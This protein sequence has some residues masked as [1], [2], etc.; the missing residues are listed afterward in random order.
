M[1]GL[2]LL[3]SVVLAFL[4]VLRFYPSP[5]A[6]AEEGV[7]PPEAAALGTREATRDGMAAAAPGEGFLSRPEPAPVAPP[8][9]TGRSDA[10]QEGGASPAADAGAPAASTRPAWLQ[11]VEVAPPSAGWEE[12]VAEAIAHGDPAAVARVL[13][14]VQAADLDDDHRRWILAFAQAL[15]DDRSR[16]LTT[17]G[18]IAEGA[19][20]ES[21]ALLLRR[22]LGGRTEE[23]VEAALRPASAIE[24]AMRLRLRAREAAALLQEKRFA[25]AARAYTEVLVT[26]LEAPW[27]SD[28]AALAAWTAGLDAAQEGHRWNPRGD[29]PSVA[30]T[31]L[32][33]DHLTG[34]RKRYLADHPDR[35]MCTGLIERANA[36]RG[37][38]HAGDELR[39][40]IDPASVLVDLDARWVLYFLGDEVA[41][42]WPAGIGRAG[43]ETITGDF[44]VGPKE[45]RPVWWPAGEEPVPYGDPR[46]PLGSH[47]IPW[48]QDGRRTS[49][50]FHGTNDPGSIGSAAS[51]GCIRMRNEDVARLFAVLPEGAPIRVRE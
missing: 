46:N 48:I 15:A 38:I 6:G 44:T 3:L 1:R 20:R 9:A 17:A 34:I 47:W 22:A 42:S 27:P 29:W 19:L 30:V 50:G 12:P 18:E 39:I 41:G 24:H 33:G 13:G 40:P 28:P 25:D 4:L 35:L 37:Y 7:A 16:A 14:G 8:P 26:E 51:E 21:E 36:L 11:D 32:D 2:I 49:Y 31:V 5:E 23:L 43:E 45:E 10:P